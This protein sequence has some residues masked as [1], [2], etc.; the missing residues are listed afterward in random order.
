MRLIEI[1]CLYLPYRIQ[2]KWNSGMIETMNAIDISN[3]DDLRSG[4]VKPI[5]KPL[6]T[7]TEEEVNNISEELNLIPKFTTKLIDLHK[8]N[9]AVSGF[10][11]VN[12]LIK[13]HYDVF[14]LIAEGKAI[15]I[16][17]NTNK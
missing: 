12:Q 10:G 6:D 3:P 9:P 8:H 4:R 11:L 5:L 1:M 14:G 2:I 13:N 16:N 7:I 17:S 15:E